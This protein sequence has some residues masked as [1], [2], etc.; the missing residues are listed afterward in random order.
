M[1]GCPVC[2]WTTDSCSEADDKQE[3]N[4]TDGPQ[5]RKINQMEK[6]SKYLN[7]KLSVGQT[8]LHFGGY[9]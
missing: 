6:E 5:I 9:V 1:G 8:K 3:A 2:T 4:K 7:L